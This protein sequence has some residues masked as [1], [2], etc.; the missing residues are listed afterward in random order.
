MFTQG[1]QVYNKYDTRGFRGKICEIGIV[2]NLIIYAYEDCCAVVELT[3]CKLGNCI[4]QDV[5]IF[6]VST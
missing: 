5:M 6:G 3:T 2:V 4:I 1:E